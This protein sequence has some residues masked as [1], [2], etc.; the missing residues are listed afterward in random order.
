MNN[1][2][3]GWLGSSLLLAG[4]LMVSAQAISQ[5][6]SDKLKW[7]SDSVQVDLHHNT[8]LA[9]GVFY[10][11]VN[12]KLACGSGPWGKAEQLTVDN[13]SKTFQFVQATY[14][15]CPEGQKTWWLEA[16]RLQLDTVEGWGHAWHAVLRWKGVPVA[17][18]PY[19]EFPIDDRRKTGFLLPH[20]GYTKQGGVEFALPYYINLA[21]NYD[22]TVTPEYIAKRGVLWQ[23][24]GRYLTRHSQGEVRLAALPHDK[25]FATFREEASTLYADDVDAV[26]GLSELASDENG[27][28]GLGLTQ[29]TQ[30]NA[31]ISSR[32][33]VNVASDAYLFY[34]FGNLLATDDRVHLLNRFQGEYANESMHFLA[35]VQAYQTLHAI[36]ETG[37]SDLYNRL[38]E[39]TLNMH[40]PSGSPHV[41]LGLEAAMV[42]FDHKRDGVTGEP[43]VTGSRLQIT[44]SL[45]LPWYTGSGFFIPRVALM[46]RDYWLKGQASGTPSQMGQVL[47]LLSVDSGLFFEGASSYHGH[48]Y[49]EVI[50]PR[51]FYVY[52][53]WRD[54]ANI[55]VFDTKT[56]PFSFAGL[57]RRNRFV[58]YDREGDAS[59]V[60]V[61]V[62]G[63]VIDGVSGDALWRLR[64]GAAYYAHKQRVCL[65]EDCA[66][67]LTYGRSFSPI[68]A[69]LQH[70]LSGHWQFLSAFAWDP[71]EHYTNN[72]YASLLY[73]PK[74]YNNLYLGYYYYKNELNQ[75]KIAVNWRVFRHWNLTGEWGYNI[76]DGHSQDILYGLNYESHCWA[77]KLVASR[78]FWGLDSDGGRDYQ[79]RYVVQLQL[80]GLGGGGQSL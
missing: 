28:Y 46:A 24:H 67:D 48:R 25:V 65:T 38:P 26:L 12:R 22:L 63:K 27:R 57:F 19:L 76:G 51:L 15:T 40:Y 8:V 64:L 20:V 49:R 41:A 32:V 78:T 1:I 43:V 34:D 52:V 9:K 60:S 11:I 73:Q 39:L 36:G 31:N 16:K 75:V 80:Q 50:E 21:P 61:G 17:Y 69:E 7:T 53:P 42:R 2:L 55:P 70:Q 10:Q 14:T 13:A 29:S 71:V 33:D 66:D 54:Q 62:T 30:L 58:G 74:P 5:Q 44:P 77:L 79:H 23:A 72:A 56:L 37:V 45:A 59:Q 4:M 3:K 6:A 68:V 18:F 35:K 47:P